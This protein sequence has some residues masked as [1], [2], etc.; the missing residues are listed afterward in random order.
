MGARRIRREQRQIDMAQSRIRNG[1]EKKKERVRR[2]T[3]MVELIKKGRLPYTPSIMSWISAQLDKPTTR[4]TQEDV[5]RLPLA[6]TASIRQAR[7]SPE[8]FP[9]P[10]LLV[11]ADLSGCHPAREQ[12]R[13]D[14]VQRLLLHACLVDRQP[15]E[16][17]FRLRLADVLSHSFVVDRHWPLASFA[18]RQPK[19]PSR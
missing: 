10:P 16:Q 3:R 13:L 17:V 12:L 6:Q 9:C 11:I 14:K 15:V 19:N 18:R 7:L 8:D 2:E 1:T 4:I 5:D